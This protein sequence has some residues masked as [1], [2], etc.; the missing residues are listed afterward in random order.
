MLGWQQ[1]RSENGFAN[2]WLCD[3]KSVTSQDLH[4]SIYKMIVLVIISIVQCL[5]PSEVGQFLQVTNVSLGW[6]QEIGSFS[7][8]GSQFNCKCTPACNYYRRA[9]HLATHFRFQIQTPKGTSALFDAR[10]RYRYSSKI[11]F[12]IQ[13]HPLLKIFSTAITLIQAHL[14]SHLES[15]SLAS[16]LPFLPSWNPFSSQQPRSF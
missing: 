12:R 8:K 9:Q 7:S 5:L 11:I 10:D 6:V 3:S 2:N 14:V 15:F 13:S 16:L 4:L 1:K